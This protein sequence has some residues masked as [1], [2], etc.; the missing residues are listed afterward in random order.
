MV[1]LVNFAGN[2]A[3]LHFTGDFLRIPINHNWIY[4]TALLCA[5]GFFKDFKP[6]EPFLNPY[7]NETKKF[8]NDDLSSQ[9]TRSNCIFPISL[10]RE[11]VSV[12]RIDHTL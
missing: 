6:S 3:L 9:V 7:L 12:F 8:D 1:L 4:P 10:F 11:V 2:Y 5:Y